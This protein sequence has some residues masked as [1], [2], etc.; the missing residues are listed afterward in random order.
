VWWL[1]S[2]LLLA[3]PELVIRAAD[4][5]PGPSQIAAEI[6]PLLPAR[7]TV[8]VDPDAHPRG[9]DSATVAIQDGRR[10]IRLQDADGRLIQQR[11]LAPFLSCSEAAR[12]AAVLIAAW[13]F[14]GRADMSSPP[15]P[16]SSVPPT[17]RPSPS[18]TASVAQPPPV[19]A[20]PAAAPGPPAGLRPAMAAA[21]AALNAA[22]TPGP[23][24]AGPLRP[25]VTAA[26]AP[27]PTPGPAST[28]LLAVG[29]GASLGVAGDSHPVGGVAE[30]LVGL[31]DHLGLR[32]PISFSA[33]YA[34]AI[35]SGHATWT[36]VG[37][38]VGGTVG[39]RY[40]G[41]GW[42]LHGEVMG[43]RL[44]ISGGEGVPLPESGSQLILGVGIGARA[45]LTT[46]R[47]A[48]LWLDLSGSAWPGRHE[49][50]ILDTS[51]SRPLP[52]LEVLGSV[53]LSYF[54]RG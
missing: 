44:G 3:D 35:G 9:A 21:P 53:G 2:A 31:T 12:A 20:P 27:S 4:G 42:L 29:A 48:A 24:A 40:S 11:P 7:I 51:E 50:F 41:W 28:M 47:R 6:A 32:L 37:A 25:I 33:G 14:Q 10:W 45:L 18:V 22:S 26:P 23:P 34:I 52:T 30:L 1:L 46:G 38:G 49:V 15:A 13:E 43:A 54:V 39:A 19:P 16:P 8:T 36:R 5:C 17:P